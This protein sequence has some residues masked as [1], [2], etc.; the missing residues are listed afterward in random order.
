MIFLTGA[1]GKT[2]I[3]IIKALSR[4]NIPVKALVRSNQQVESL[5]EFPG[6]EPVVGDL[7]NPDGFSS[8]LKDIDSLYFICPNVTP[9]E[10]EIGQNLIQL[11]QKLSIRHFCYH[12]VLHP[13]I[14]DMPHHW[15]KLRMEES[16]FKSGLAYTILQPCAYMQNILGGWSS[17]ITGK[18]ITPYNVNSRIS[19]VD[20]NDVAA[21]AARIMTQPG[22]DFAIYELAGPQALSQNEVAR[23]LS[24]SLKIPVA[25]IEQ[26]RESWRENAVKNG[27]DGYPL[28]TLLQ[29]FE[30]YDKFGFVGN[31]TTL[32]NLLN[33]EPTSFHQ[34]L[35]NHLNS[36]E[37]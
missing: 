29:M 26:T 8:A 21:A 3:A 4:D 17:I 35:Q 36:G 22:H 9:D 1:A 11:S 10:F 14:E 19:I 33:R 13:Q 23:E 2:G 27:M 18:Y 28:Q 15:Q 16:L 34:F 5:R 12:S 6:C 30:Y 37:Y 25:A 32:H 31:S 20:L 24:S 7:R